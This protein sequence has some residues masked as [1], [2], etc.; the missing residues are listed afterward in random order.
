MYVSLRTRPL[1]RAALAALALAVSAVPIVVAQTQG[2]ADRNDRRDQP[3]QAAPKDAPKKAEPAPPRP[4]ATDP[5]AK[6]D[7]SAEAKAAQK[8]RPALPETPAE[9]DKMLADLYAHLA[10]AADEE[11]AKQAAEGI[12]RI[13]RHSGSDT[14]NL[15]MERA[16]KAV[17]DKKLDLA[18]RLLDSALAI[19]PDYTEGWNRRAYVHFSQQKLNEALGDIRRVLAL[20]PNH[21]KALDG[22]GNI[23]RELG[24]KRG[25]L[26]AFK[27][28][29]DVHPFWP[30]LKTTIEELSREVDGRGI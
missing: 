19:A 13:W 24:E 10:T 28:L 21:F 15:L 1:A 11:G 16:T 14:I 17:H 7:P 12:E 5:H 29:E 23:L 4:G 25:A 18:L 6:G 30:N 26:K 2:P 3:P 22:L 8:K 9:R 27:Q 20:D